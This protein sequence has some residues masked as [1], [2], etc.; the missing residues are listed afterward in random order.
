VENSSPYKRKSVI[1][2]AELSEVD[3]TDGVD[4]DRADLLR[5]TNI[6]TSRKDIFWVFMK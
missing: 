4:K 2:T 3:T 1:F 5:N 6:G